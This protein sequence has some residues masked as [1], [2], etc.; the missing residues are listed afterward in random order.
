MKHVIAFPVLAIVI[1]AYLL[2]AAGGA[3]MIDADAYST[4]LMSGTEMTLRG[5]DFF[6]IAG[7]VALVVDVLKLQGPGRP[8]PVQHGL[9]I[10]TFLV[11]LNCLAMFDYAGTASFFLLV[12]MAL[13]LVLAGAIATL[14]NMRRGD[15]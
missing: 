14:L 10:V 8:S 3:M 5:G 15:R 11:A 12:V 9:A 6:L 7:L 2:M 1:A 4:T 13:L